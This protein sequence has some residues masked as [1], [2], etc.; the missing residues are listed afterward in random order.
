MAVVLSC[1]LNSAT[2]PPAC[3]AI[4][5]IASSLALPLPDMTVMVSYQAPT[6]AFLSFSSAAVRT[7][8]M[9]MISPGMLEESKTRFAPGVLRIDIRIGFQVT[10]DS[11]G[12]PDMNTE[13]MSASLVFTILMSRSLS[14]ALSSA[15][16]R[17]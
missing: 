2:V 10:T 13:P 17:R 14:L 12:P 6:S 16:A 1:A 15:R 9:S 5:A 3:C 4:A 8:S 7:T 11:V